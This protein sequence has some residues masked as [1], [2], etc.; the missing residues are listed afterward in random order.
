MRYDRRPPPDKKA[1]DLHAN[2][3]QGPRTQVLVRTPARQCMEPCFVLGLEKLTLAHTL[4]QD[5]TPA[6]PREGDSSCGHPS[7]CINPS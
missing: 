6:A 5:K 1:L 7:D 3:A 4:P 2:A